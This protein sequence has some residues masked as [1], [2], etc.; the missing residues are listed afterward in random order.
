MVPVTT[1]VT[2]TETGE[3]SFPLPFASSFAPMALPGGTSMLAIFV[4]YDGRI[5]T[6]RLAMYICIHI[7]IRRKIDQVLFLEK[8]PGDGERFSEISVQSFGRGK[9]QSEGISVRTAVN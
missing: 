4:P 7:P 9:D 2:L 6:E 8:G 3:P 5:V 1:R